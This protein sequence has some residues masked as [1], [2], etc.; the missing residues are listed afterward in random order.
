MDTKDLMISVSGVRGVVG[1]S[2]TPEIFTRFAAAFGTLIGPHKIVVGMDTRQSGD[3]IKHAVHAGL[4]SVGC[5]PL[6]LGICPTPTVGLMVRTLSAKGGVAITASHNPAEWNAVKF[7]RENGLLLNEALGEELLRLFHQEKIQRS[8]WQNLKPVESVSGAILTHLSRIMGYLDASLIWGKRFKVALDC[9][10]GAGSVIGPQLL[11]QVGCEAVLLHVTPNGNFP[12]DPEPVAENLCQLSEAVRSSEADV[13]FAQDADVD[14]I[15]LVDEKGRVL[16]EEYTLALAVQYVLSKRK[17]PVVVN[18]STT[19]AIEDIA[20]AYGC[21][22]VRTKVGEVNVAER[23][24]ELGSP[25]GGEGNGG[26]ILPEVALGRDATAAMGL[27]LESMAAS[28]KR[29]SELADDLP[30]YAIV[31]EKHSCPRDAVEAMLCVV[32]ETFSGGRVDETQGIR[33]DWDD[34]WIHIRP[35]GTEP[36]VRVI[37]EAKDEALAR[38][39]C[40]RG[41]RI[42]EEFI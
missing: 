20:S 6:E 29:L 16:G 15:G 1:K 3:M 7:V 8:Q 19:R 32:R 33:I 26:V 25:V 35:S 40:E 34:S 38:K 31:K 9:C 28:G 14:R 13:G 4:I 12:H 23:M 22:L 5:Q 10:N 42:I 17:G 11:Q 2:A 27:I 39:L 30:K 37:A 21:S 36:V 41:R 24:L 18:L